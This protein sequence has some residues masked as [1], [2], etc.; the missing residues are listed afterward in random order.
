MKFLILSIL[1]ALSLSLSQAYAD[2]NATKTEVNYQEKLDESLKK[3]EI[4]LKNSKVENNITIGSDYNT[5]GFYYN[6]TDQTDNALKYYLKAVKIVEDQKKPYSKKK[7]IYYNNLATA[8][9]KLNKY[10]EALKYYA[11]ALDIYKEKLPEVHPFIATTSSDIGNVYEK[12]GNKDK[13]L[14]YQLAALKIRIKSVRPMN[15]PDIMYSYEKVASLYEEKGNYKEA[16]TYG[17]KLM[18]LLDI[19][20]KKS[21][22]NLKI[23]LDQLQKKIDSQKTDKIKN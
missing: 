13:A 8:Y 19:K 10:P 16:L 22:K 2:T 15:H 5:V 21:R 9:E 3:L 17:K 20:D 23:K 1:V 18:E 12:M 11:Q 7:S 4:D 14:E 6:K